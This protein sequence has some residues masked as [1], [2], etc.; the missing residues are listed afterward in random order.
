MVEDRRPS[1]WA[2]L[3]FRGHRIG[4]VC[5]HPTPPGLK[6]STGEGRRNSRVRDAELVLIAREIANFK[7]Q[8]WLVAGD[9]NDVAWSH[10]TRLFKRI[11]GLNDPRVGRSFMGTF[12]SRSPLLRVP[13]DHLFVSD[14]F[15]ILSLSRHKTSGSDHFAVLGELSL[16][17]S[18]GV[19]PKPQG[20]D[21]QEANQLIAEGVEDAAARDVSA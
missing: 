4:F 1:I 13:L 12:H 17:R 6:D 15:E 20:D 10:T 3:D 19:T 2:S 7:D 5:V 8:A 11:S 18:E 9:F 16:R 21:Q 14:G